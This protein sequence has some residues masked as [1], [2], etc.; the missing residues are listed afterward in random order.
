MQHLNISPRE[1]EKFEQL[2]Q[3][4]GV[5][6]PSMEARGTQSNKGFVDNLGPFL[7]LDRLWYSSSALGQ[8]VDITR[9][10]FKQLE[11]RA[12]FDTIVTI[13][14]SVG[15]LGPAPLAGIFALEFRKNLII[16]AE[17]QFGNLAAYPLTSSLH[18]LFYTKKILILK[19][20]ITYA[21]S[22][23]KATDVIKQYEGIPVAFMTLVDKRPPERK[24]DFKNLDNSW[25]AVL[26]DMGKQDGS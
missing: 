13:L 1:K 23:E 21:S 5:I 20:I 2:L 22:L 10:V 11:Q 16:L 8:L 24:Y 12:N 26:K 7:D 14:G 3:N 18:S 25:Y 19:D 9:P 15:S 4:E 17:A 6:R